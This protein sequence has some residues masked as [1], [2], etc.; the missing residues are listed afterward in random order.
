VI[1]VIRW[2]SLCLSAIGMGLSLF[3]LWLST[4]QNKRLL[5]ENLELS[6]ANTMLQALCN[7]YE[8]KIARL[9]EENENGRIC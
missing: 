1:E 5:R 2:V 8:A 4:R 3:S 9:R 6:T 7:M